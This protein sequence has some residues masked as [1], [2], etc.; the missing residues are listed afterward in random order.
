MPSYNFKAGDQVKI[1]EGW[2]NEGKVGI[3]LGPPVWVAQ[4]WVPVLWNTKEPP[5]LFQEAGLVPE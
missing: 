1:R 4:S 5:T 3:V 2:D